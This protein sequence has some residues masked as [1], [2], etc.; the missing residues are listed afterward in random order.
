M[1]FKLPFAAIS[2]VLVLAACQTGGQKDAPATGAAT[3]APSAGGPATSGPA[4]SGPATGGAAPVNSAERNAVAAFGRICGQLN[5]NTVT[6]RAVQFGFVPAR[7][8]ALPADLRSS[9]ERT[10]GTMLVRPTG[11]P[12]MLI[13]SE[14]QTCELWVGG[15]ELPVMEQEFGQLI[16]R[17]A[18]APN[19]RSTV[20]RISPEEAA[21]MRSPHGS[22][23]RQGALIAPRELVATPPRVIVL[24]S[25]ESPGAFR[26]LMIHRVAPPPPGPGAPAATATPAGQPKDPVR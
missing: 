14:P 24:R 2:V 16:G 18:D 1:R 20:T 12:A 15:V 10:N 22:R 6:E 3:G 9:L 4:T 26:A 7:N 5:R 19:S 8:E 23:V 25:T 11:A 13:W 21:R 17:I